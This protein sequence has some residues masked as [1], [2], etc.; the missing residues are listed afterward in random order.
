LQVAESAEELCA[1]LKQLRPSEDTAQ[2]Y[3]ITDVLERSQFTSVRAC[4][5]LALAR[6][7]T[8]PAQSWLLDLADD[9]EPEVHKVALGALATREDGVAH[10]AVVEA[11][12]SVDAA[13]RVAA[14]GA[15]LSARRSEA[16]ALAKASLQAIDDADTLG[17]LTDALG[18][19]GDA[20]A[21]PVLKDLIENGARSLHLHALTAVGAL[22]LAEGAGLVEPYLRLGSEDEFNA[23]AKALAL[24]PASGVERELTA[25]LH[26]GN[27]RRRLSAL[28]RL[29]ELD[30]PTLD[31]ILLEAAEADDPNLVSFALSR[32]S[33]RR[34]PS[35]LPLF[36]RA[37]RRGSVRAREAALRALVALATPAAFAELASLAAGSGQVAEMAVDAMLR[38]P[39]LR[40]QAERR[41]I[42]DLQSFSANR[43]LNSLRTLARDSSEAGQA[44]LLDYVSKSPAGEKHWDVVLNALPITALAKWLPAAN[45]EDPRSRQ[46]FF[47]ALAD[48]GDPKAAA[49]LRSA[50][51]DS[52]PDTRRSAIRGLVSLAAEGSNDLLE[53][54]VKSSTTEDRLLGVTLLEAQTGASAQAALADLARDPDAEV[55]TQSLGVLGQRAPEEAAQVAGRAMRSGTPESRQSMLGALSG[56]NRELA[57]PVI[58]SALADP[59]NATAS[60]A[61]TCLGQFEGPEVARLLYSVVVDAQRAQEVRTA[62]AAALYALGGPIV[63]SN[64]ALIESLLPAEDP[65]ADVID[66][67]RKSARGVQ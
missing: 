58:E 28:R 32:L 40:A 22:G 5:A 12:H 15:L 39:S 49:L 48:R 1:L 21:F 6:E 14:I 10:A 38:I 20:R 8:A 3:A 26:A 59:D 55:A 9:V 24:L 54:L 47:A 31:P 45:D 27:A 53:G 62:A 30:V 52:D 23:A 33:E 46:E 41:R 57:L 43:R 65:H 17:E 11:A 67:G 51:K 4:G 35:L 2:T 7:P 60:G 37:S 18:A 25:L 13:V 29:A 61:L 42:D 56:W 34:D 36:A 63:R 64:Q 44:A 16:F 19:S 50:T 66:E